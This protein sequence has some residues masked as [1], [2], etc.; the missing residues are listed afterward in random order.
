MENFSVLQSVY[1]NDKAAYLNDCFASLYNSTIK[2]TEIILV[3]DG[4][5]T[6]EINSVIDQWK[7]KLWNSQY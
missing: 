4:P 5:V 2:P 7:S 6:D 1:R 3:K